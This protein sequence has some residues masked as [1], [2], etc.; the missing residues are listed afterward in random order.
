VLRRSWFLLAFLV[1]LGIVARR[2]D[3]LPRD[4]TPLALHLGERFGTTNL[5]YNVQDELTNV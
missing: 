5:T 4:E 2:S 3:D 1:L